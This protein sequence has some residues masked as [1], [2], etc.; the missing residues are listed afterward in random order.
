MDLAELSILQNAITFWDI[1]WSDHS[2][3]ALPL[4]IGAAGSLIALPTAQV[5]RLLVSVFF[6]RVLLLQRVTLRTG[7]Y[8][9]E[10]IIPWKPDSA[11][12]KERIYLTRLGQL[13]S[14]TYRGFLIDHEDDGFRR[15]PDGRPIERVFG[16]FHEQRQ[17]VGNWYHPFP[18]RREVGAFNLEDTKQDGNLGGVWTGKSSTY[19][20]VLSGSWHWKKVEKNDYGLLKLYTQKLFKGR[21]HDN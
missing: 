13:N 17:F 16:R 4:T 10:Y 19:N 20:K 7:V 9:C 21:S 14:D 18:N 11:P 5:L 12:I 2:D 15:T 8:E 3:W 1:I 6:S